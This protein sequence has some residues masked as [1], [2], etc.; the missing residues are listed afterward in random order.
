ME[1]SLADVPARLGQAITSCLLPLD[2]ASLAYRCIFVIAGP[3]RYMASKVT[4]LGLKVRSTFFLYPF[5]ACVYI[6]RKS[7]L[8]KVDRSLVRS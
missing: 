6:F 4:R 5:L 2:S 3:V 1:V 8:F 7:G